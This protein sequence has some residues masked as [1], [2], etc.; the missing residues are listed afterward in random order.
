MSIEKS[1]KLHFLGNYLRNFPKVRTIGFSRL[2]TSARVNFLGTEGTG[3]P[4][5]RESVSYFGLT[6]DA[7]NQIVQRLVMTKHQANRSKERRYGHL[8]I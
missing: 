5:C 4:M 6:G 3:E 1:E 7:S 8:N 2:R